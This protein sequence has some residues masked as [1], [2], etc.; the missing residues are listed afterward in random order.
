MHGI[1]PQFIVYVLCYLAMGLAAVAL[2]A[3]GIMIAVNKI[4]QTRV[5]GA[6]YIITAVSSAAV[7]TYNVLISF[8]NSEKVIVYGD[9]VMIGTLFCVFASSLCICIYIHK[10]Y[11]Q[12]HIY[13]PVLLL[14]FVVMLA[15]AGAVLMFNRIMTETIGQA[16]LISLVNDV[17]NI[18]TV[19]LIAIVII[20]VLYRNREKEKIIPKAWLVKGITVIWGIA[21]IVI[22]SIVYISVIA[23]VE[24]GDYDASS[25]NTVMFLSIVQAVDSIVAVI[26]PFY[27]LSRVRKASKQE[28]AA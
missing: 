11:G 25:D 10:T 18:V 22:I 24:A 3:A 14:P 8:Y 20:I 16:M 6:G 26:V 19:T 15:D 13:I 17:N 23:L 27:V 1:A 2:F 5:L 4:R 12:K 28:K 9:A 7:F 21:E